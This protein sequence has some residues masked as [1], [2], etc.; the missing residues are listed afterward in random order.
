MSSRVALLRSGGQRRQEIGGMID[1]NKA[2]DGLL[3][4]PAASDW[5]ALRL[6]IPGASMLGKTPQLPSWPTGEVPITVAPSRSVT[7]SP[8]APVPVT[9]GLV[10][11]VMLSPCRPLSEPGRSA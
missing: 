10:A 3:T 1:R 8:G 6:W 5:I 4:L 2:A 7:P 11:V 9:I